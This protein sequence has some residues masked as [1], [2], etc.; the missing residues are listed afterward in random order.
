MTD[1][2][3]G[4]TGIIGFVP[5]VGGYRV[6]VQK[7]D[8]HVAWIIVP[9]DTHEALPKDAWTPPVPQKDGLVAYK[10]DGCDIEVANTIN[11]DGLSI[12]ASFLQWILRLADG[13]V[14]TNRGSDKIDG[15]YLYV[16]DPYLISARLHVIAGKLKAYQPSEQYE[17]RWVGSAASWRRITQLAI[18]AFEID[19]NKLVLW[20]G[21]R[22]KLTVWGK[23]PISVVVGNTLKSN[24]FPQGDPG[25]ELDTHVRMYYD[26]SA[27]SYPTEFRPGL[28][29]RH[30]APGPPKAKSASP[31]FQWGIVRLGGSNCPPGLWTG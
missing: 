1:V 4:Y 21:T 19:E 3:I 10:L 17:W 29:K 20:C 27:V 24:I 12:D 8:G 31:A 6:V 16:D 11:E 13:V 14:P 7:A 18:N 22:K 23:S 30:A 9:K 26:L 2:Q 28:I 25:D 5:Q 15:K